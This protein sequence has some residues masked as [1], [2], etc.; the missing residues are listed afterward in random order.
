MSDLQSRTKIVAKNT[1]ITLAT[2]LIKNVLSFI[3]RTIF[4]YILGAEY[5]GV[6]GLFSEILVVL[7]FAELGVGNALVYSMYKPLAEKNESKLKSLMKLYAQAYRIIGIVILGA[8]LLL[9]PFLP[10][11]VGEVSYVK[12]NIVFLYVLSLLSTVST[13]FLVYKKSMLIAD[14]KMYVVN[15]YEELFH[16]LAVV[17]QSIFLLITREYI[18][19]LL[20]S[21]GMGILNNVC[22]A[23]RANK[24][25]PFLK[26][27]NVLKLD[28][29]EWNEIIK[30]VK[31]L[32]I[33]KI[34]G[35]ILESTDNI[36]I[37]SLI[38]VV[39][40]GL[41]S[42]YRMIVNIFKNIGVQV[43]NSVI[44]SVGNMQA[45]SD[46]QKKKIIFNELLFICAWFYGFTSAG[47]FLFLSDFVEIWLGDKYILS[48]TE[49][50]ALCVYYYISNM[51]YAAYT[52]R[53]TAG[54]FI[55]GK[56]IPLIAAGLNIILDFVLGTKMG[57]AGIIWASSIS[58]GLTYEIVDPIFIYQ[59]LFNLSI[60]DYVLR[61]T[62]Y[63][64][65]ITLEVAILSPILKIL[66]VY[67]LTGLVVK[68]I[69]FTIVFNLLF[70]IL[71]F[72]SDEEKAIL[73]R[74]KA[75][76]KRS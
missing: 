62:R 66:P 39:T 17:L 40:V 29:K 16:I 71:F 11:I 15:I 41:Y 59:K 58:R 10:E 12:E 74:F 24:M 8:G 57:L 44:A 47:L 18:V 45:T 34:G 53:T 75:I 64:V 5:L 70:F 43:M 65:A 14:Q 50:L 35:T 73:H 26:E 63:V 2:Q 25:Y 76:L 30:N 32:F 22:V 1:V 6:N 48:L 55:F 23:C 36:F 28:R 61:Y 38:N 31:A 7:S 20:I 33:Y 60:R 68:A 54:L 67:G 46:A 3:S 9:I 72:K 13:Y 19:Y 51:H 37:S 27:K 56:W 52:Y 69:I 21:I 49:V 42:N 4:I